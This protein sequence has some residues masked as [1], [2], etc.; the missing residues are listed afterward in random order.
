MNERRKVPPELARA[1]F[2]SWAD[3]AKAIG[4]HP[5]H[6]YVVHRGER[7]LSAEF[8]SRLAQALN[9]PEQDVEAIVIRKSEQTK[10]DP[11]KPVPPRHVASDERSRDAIAMSIR[12]LDREAPNVALALALLRDVSVPVV[13]AEESEVEPQT[14]APPVP[15]AWNRT[16]TP[17]WPGEKFDKLVAVQE[18]GLG[19]GGGLRWIFRCECGNEVNWRVSLVRRN[20][21]HGYCACPECYFRD[22]PKAAERRGYVSGR[23]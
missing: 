3:L 15:S 19:P 6:L 5:A 22:H 7:G 16:R 2:A 17:P 1:G 11:A 10:P 4:T 12:A 20:V 9:V 23:R 18:A 21:S 14:K 8:R 13:N